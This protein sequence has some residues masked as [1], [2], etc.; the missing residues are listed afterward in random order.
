MKTALTLSVAEAQKI[1]SEDRSYDEVKIEVARPPVFRTYSADEI[2]SMTRI[3][4]D[5][6]KLKNGI[7]PLGNKIPAIKAVRE[8]TKRGNYDNASGPTADYSI[9]GLAEA[10]NFVEAILG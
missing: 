7:N 1:I 2:I 10:K 5:I 9:M 8:F 6:L 3:A 4:K